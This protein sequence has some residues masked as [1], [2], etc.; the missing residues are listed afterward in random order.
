MRGDHSWI[1]PV[2]HEINTLFLQIGER[3]AA[4]HILRAWDEIPNER[5]VSYFRHMRF[6]WVTIC[7]SV[8][9]EDALRDI[10]EY[11]ERNKLT[12]ARDEVLA[13]QRTALGRERLKLCNNAADDPRLSGQSEFP[14][15]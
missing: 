14:T 5:K 3:E 2:L 8:Q 10:A 7:Q 4:E 11:L 9:I 1:F 15:D 12:R 13:A 6:N